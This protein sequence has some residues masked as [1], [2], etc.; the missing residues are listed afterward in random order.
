MWK[1]EKL[2]M[3]NFIDNFMIVPFLEFKFVSFRLAREL[4]MGIFRKLEKI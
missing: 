1:C 2:Q 3:N 4:S